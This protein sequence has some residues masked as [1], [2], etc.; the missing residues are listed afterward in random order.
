MNIDAFGVRAP[1]ASWAQSFG[2]AEVTIRARLSRGWSAEDAVTR[3]THTQLQGGIY[4]AGE[5]SREKGGL[6]VTRPHG[7]RK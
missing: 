2:L 7:G 4:P 3:P 1:A 6:I 5:G